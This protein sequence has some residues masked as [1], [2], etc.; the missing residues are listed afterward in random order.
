MH[1]SVTD[2]VSKNET[3]GCWEITIESSEYRYF[4]HVIRIYEEDLNMDTWTYNRLNN[5]PWL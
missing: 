2:L 5:W 1:W 3:A 4:L